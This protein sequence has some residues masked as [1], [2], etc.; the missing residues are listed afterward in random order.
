MIRD[1]LLTHVQF[2][3]HLCDTQMTMYLKQLSSLLFKKPQAMDV[4]LQFTSPASI[5]QPLCQCLDDW[6]Y[7]SDQGERPKHV[8]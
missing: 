5:L 3:A 7:E 2:V 1:A 4:I 8:D 6:H